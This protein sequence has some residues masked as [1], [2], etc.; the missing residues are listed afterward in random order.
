MTIIEPYKNNPLATHFLYLGLLILASAVL[1]IYF[2]NQNVSLRYKVTL[3]ER[4]IQQQEV[5]NG[6]VRNQLYQRLDP[7]NLTAIIQK[8][9]LIPEKTPAYLSKTLANSN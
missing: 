9:N 6:D 7:R 3:R 4:F 1:N 8:Q 5:V 2:Y